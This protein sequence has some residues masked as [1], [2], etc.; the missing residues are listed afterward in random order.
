M[1]RHIY[2]LVT[3]LSAACG[4]VVEI[5]A[6]RMLAPYLGMSLYTW[7]AIIAVVLAGFSA[8][9]WIG[10]RAA[11]RP[12]QSAH[13]FVV[14]SLVG[15]ALSSVAALILIRLLSGPILSMNVGAVPTILLLTT[16]LFFLPSLFVGIPSPVL[17]K[18]AIDEN[19]DLIARTLGAFYAVGALGSIIGT[20]AAGYIFISWLGTIWTFLL[21]AASYA[22]M[23]LLLLLTGT[24]RD[25]PDTA[26]GTATSIPAAV[27]LVGTVGLATLGASMNAFRN[28]CTTE[29]AYYCIRTISE[30]PTRNGPARTLILDHLAHGT[31][32][33]GD[34][35]HL[36]SPYV[37]LQDI[38]ARI[39]TGRTT[40]FR[41]YFIGGGAYTL[42]RAWLALRPDAQL[43]ISEIDPAVT[44]TAAE[45]LWLKH[46]DNRMSIIH[47]DA[48]TGLRRQPESHFDIIVGDA[49]HDI[50]V[51]Q[52]LVS[53]ELFQLVA[54]RLTKDGI[55]VMN[56]VDRLRQPRLALSVVKTMRP[57]FPHVEIWALNE[58]GARTTLIIAGVKSPTPYDTIPSSVAEGLRFSRLP[59]SRIRQLEAQTQPVLLTDDFAPVDRLIGV[60]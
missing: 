56:V 19:P 5:A 7:T 15:A 46:T 2:L 11:E 44:K 40:P 43:T 3:A 54:S 39:H 50:T 28:P 45:Q 1:R 32:V 21:V 55:Y 13:R 14:W 36:L 27:L 4:L 41:A 20:L 29:S 38:L 53:S 17:T 31:N 47:E 22:A 37:E 58:T 25:A 24:G 18:L 33:Q 57:L 9:H 8:G 49:F 23:A 59:E 10:G 12:T 16:L 48:R 35:R 51:P 52:H 60:Q 6:G 42:P 26:Q 34:P 30:T